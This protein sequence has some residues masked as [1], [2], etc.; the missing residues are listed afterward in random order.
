MNPELSLVIPIRN[1][2]PNIGALYTE[3][4]EALERW[5]RSYEVIAVDDGST[6]DSFECLARCQQRDPRWRIIRFRRNFGQTAA[7]AAG[8]RHARGRLIATSDGDLQNDPRDLPDMICRIEEGNDIVCGW[9]KARKDAWLT[10]RVPSAM[11]N[12][13]ISWSTG[14][15]LH[16]YG[17]SLKVFRSEVVKP[18]KLYGEM[19]RFLPAIASEMG[20]KIAEVVVNHRARK[21]GT[22]NYGLSRT[23][24]VVLDL[25]TVKFLLSYSTRPL[26][27]F[28][29]IGVPMGLI[30]FL[31]AVF[32]SYERLFGYESIANRPLLLLAVL[33]IFSGIQLLTMGL[34]AEIMSRTYHESQDK[35][36]Y[37]IREVRETSQGEAR[38]HSLSV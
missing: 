19:H 2:S 3:L 10:R 5:G 13:L 11:A 22:S 35:P 4:T 14:V 17:C 21:H 8:F 36:T 27:M 26:Q 30:G 6:D 34:L 20:V 12:I 1:E 7:F 18:I 23:F 33:L 15:K 32:L 38:P 25:L 24:R 29:L 28:G 9:R 31:I 37:V 16:D